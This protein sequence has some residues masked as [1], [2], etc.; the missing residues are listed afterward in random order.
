MRILKK[1]Y[2][3]LFL[4]LHCLVSPAWSQ[5]TIE[6]PSPDVTLTVRGPEKAIDYINPEGAAS[7]NDC[8]VLFSSG[9]GPSTGLVSRKNV[10]I[11]V[12]H[13]MKVLRV[14]NPAGAAKES[15]SF[16]ESSDIGIPQGGF[17]LVAV[18]SQYATKGYKKFV[19]E[20]FKPG[21]VV[22]LRIAGEEKPLS[23]VVALGGKQPPVRLE[24][25]VERI[26]TSIQAKE[27]ISGSVCNREQGGNYKL[28]LIVDGKTVRQIK[29]DKQGKFV[30]PVDLKPGVNY[31]D[32][33]L[34]EGKVAKERQSFVVFRK[35]ANTVQPEV[36]MWVEQFPNAKTLQTEADIEKMMQQC[37]AA[38]VT[39]LG[40]DVKGPEGYVSYKKNDLSHSPY[41][42]ATTN[43]NKKVPESDL[44][45]LESFIKYAHQY[46]MKVYASLNCFT[47]GNV[48][49]GDYAVLKEHPEWEEVVQRPEDKGRLLKISESTAGKEAR[50]G[51]RVILGFVNPASKDVQDFQLLRFEEVLKNYAVD[52]VV[53]D[54]C[55]YD[56]LYAD[57]SEV[58]RKEFEAYLERQ[59]KRLQSFPADAFLIDSEGKMI[60]GK[61]F[62]EWIT[63][64][65]SV[66]KGFTDRVRA[67][68]D[69]YKEEKNP[70]LKLA[71]YVGSWFEVYWQNGVN[72][73]S[74]G[75]QYNK[76]LNF[77]ESRLY[78]KEYAQT[79]YLDN[80]D[81]L[82]IGT[83]YKTGK[84]VNKYITLGNILTGGKLPL[85]GSMSLPD[86]NREEQ[87]EVFAASLTNSAGLMLFDYCYVD[88]N[89]FIENMRKALKQAGKKQ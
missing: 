26:Y 56:N 58:S 32:V 47:E 25:D 5:V 8:I 43:P 16:T 73:S 51:K 35:E 77:P 50:Q 30:F 28:S 14:V 15:P 78:T 52:G 85:Y 54:R 82:M 74:T 9:F 33:S 17:V 18:D 87:A 57:F 80:L 72:W 10:A 63:F 81:F 67:L 4:L 79:S 53:L 27:Q 39:A 38:G 12:D 13:Q 36:V 68:V 19:A 7:L 84:E 1:Q 62:Q 23:E 21:D 60:E 34:S 86:L 22:K 76:A 49:T 31:L 24:F 48:T 40:I 44:D 2:S 45:L 83:Y 71:A 6:A 61:Y 70:D 42:T 55:R 66:I 29:P 88:W 37:R 46:G 41:F 69:R 59:G 75:F 89:H 65:S 11:Q 64:R 20:N 3:L